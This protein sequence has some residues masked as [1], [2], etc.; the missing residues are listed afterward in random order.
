M[1]KVN[2]S[3]VF[4]ILEILPKLLSGDVSDSTY[5]H[6]SEL[7]KLDDRDGVREIYKTLTEFPWISAQGK[8]SI[9]YAL[10]IDAS[11]VRRSSDYD[12]DGN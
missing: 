6:I 9:R 12:D 5:S 7:L 11:I 3:T 1:Q 4:E 8:E 2:C 10:R